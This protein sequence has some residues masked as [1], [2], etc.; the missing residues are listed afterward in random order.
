MTQERK[1]QYKIMREA[2]TNLLGD[3][4]ILCGN[5]VGPSNASWQDVAGTAMV[6]AEVLASQLKQAH[7]GNH[8]AGIVFPDPTDC[9]EVL[10]REL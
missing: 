1:A 8:E 10:L 9:A 6:N 2:L 4:N 5:Q 3:L 7:I